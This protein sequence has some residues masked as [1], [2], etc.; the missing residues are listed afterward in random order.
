MDIR[1]LKISQ[2]KVYW[3]EEVEFQGSQEENMRRP[4]SH[5]EFDCDIQLCYRID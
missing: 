5:N 3:H 2:S 4:L 1:Q